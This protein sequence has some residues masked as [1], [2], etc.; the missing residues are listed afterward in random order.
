M[1]EMQ[2]Q[3]M[4]LEDI[5]RALKKRWLLIISVTL[6]CLIGGSIFVLFFGPEPV[7]Q[8]STTVLV[9]YRAEETNKLTQSDLTTSQKL[10]ATYTEIIKSATILEPVIKALDLE[11]T[12]DEL[13]K[14]IG[15]AQLNDTEIIKITVK[16]EDPE[17]SRDIANTIANVFSKEISKIMKVDSTSTL[18][19]AKTP[20]TPLSQNKITK[21]AIAGILGMMISVGLVFVLEYLDRT[22]KTADETEK[23]LGV[24][25]LGV[26]PKSKDLA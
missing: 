9:N 8:A 25:V 23:L 26:I 11:I 16:N 14:N 18:D 3:E 13:L 15:V 7:Y 12:A 6:M 4:T 22:V 5:F 17:L 10:V 19:V 20:T 21:I 24:P 2:Y 1:E